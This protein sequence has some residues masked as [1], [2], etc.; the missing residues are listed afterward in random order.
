MPYTISVPRE[1]V[2]KKIFENLILIQGA[3]LET[4]R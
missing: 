4:K 2:Q 3:P 1:Q